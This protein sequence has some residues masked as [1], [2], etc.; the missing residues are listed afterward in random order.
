M[1]QMSE[2]NKTN[3]FDGTL[4]RVHTEVIDSSSDDELKTNYVKKSKVISLKAW[5]RFL[6]IG[7]ADDETLKM[8]SP[9][10][11]QKGLQ[12]LAGEPKTVKKLRNGSLLVEC[13]TESH[14][15]NLLKSKSLCGI[16]I[17]VNPHTYLNSSK[18]VIRSRDLEGVSEEEICENLSSQGVTSVKR[19]KVR[20]NNELVPTNTF[21]LTF[22][23][24]TLPNSVK[25][26]YLHI[27]VVPYIPNPLRC[28]KCNK[29][30]HGQNTCRNI[31]TCARCGQLDHES[32]ACQNDMAC[33]N[34]GGKDFAYSRECPK[35]KLEKM[36]QQVKVERNLSFTEARKVVESSSPAVK[37]KSYAAAV[38]VST[39]NIATQT[40]LTWS[41]GE[42][43]YKK[44]SDIEK[45]KKK[46]AK[47]HKQNTKSAQVSL[48]V[49]P[50]PKGL[51]IGEPGPSRHM[52]GTDTKKHKK[53]SLSAR[54]KKAEKQL[55]PTNNPYETLAEMDDLM[56]IPEDRPQNKKSPKTK[57]TPI[58]P[59]ND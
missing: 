58:L 34:C 48:D 31:L 29:F 18:G 40:D 13:S 7:S 30:G 8:L 11:I 46:I 17:T 4:K 55:V 10:A 49:K 50:P 26:G 12:G 32:K 43:K 19:I 47:A 56:D 53:D 1:N 24:P 57:I 33:T 5:P 21:I 59:P 27:P 45:T 6:V 38:K 44:I 51:P 2:Q 28:F 20:R 39:S 41:N 22:D 14:S 15:K 52:S 16:S 9:F 25:A 35:W 23:V 42:D 54:L 37:D 36:V 3:Y